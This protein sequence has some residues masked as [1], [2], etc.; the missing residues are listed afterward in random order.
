MGNSR[1]RNVS[2]SSAS[3]AASSARTWQHL[4]QK[5][6]GALLARRSQNFLRW[7]LF[8]DLPSIHEHYS[9]GYTRGEVELVRDD[10]RGHACL[11]E[12]L[13]DF[14]HFVDHLRVE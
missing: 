9:T 14:K 1:R 5:G 12:L 3:R 11:R 6:A 2:A 7:S 4:A 13:N 10:E 8:Y